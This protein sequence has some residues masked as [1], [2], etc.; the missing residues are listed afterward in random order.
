M[1][2]LG[3]MKSVLYVGLVLIISAGVTFVAENSAK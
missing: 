3:N 2:T 1:I